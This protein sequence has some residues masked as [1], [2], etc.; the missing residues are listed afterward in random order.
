MYYALKGIVVDVLKD[1]IAL[2]V[3]ALRRPQYL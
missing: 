3:H 1:S 2:D